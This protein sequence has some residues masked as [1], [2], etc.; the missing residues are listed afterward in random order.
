MDINFRLLR[1]H[2]FSNYV[3]ICE[4]LVHE[5]CHIVCSLKDLGIYVRVYEV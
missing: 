4:R 5:S 1:N 3:E 2:V